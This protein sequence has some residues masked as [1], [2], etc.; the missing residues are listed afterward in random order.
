MVELGRK[1]MDIE[2]FGSKL[3]EQ[4]VNNK[5]DLDVK[6][7]WDIISSLLNKFQLEDWVKKNPPLTLIDR[8]Q[9]T[10]MEWI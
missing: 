10:L 4:L 7:H 2:G 6:Y 3:V 8:K 9:Q 1:S 5:I